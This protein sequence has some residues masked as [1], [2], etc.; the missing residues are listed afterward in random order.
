MLRKGAAQIP[1]CLG[2]RGRLVIQFMARAGKKL[3][4]DLLSDGTQRNPAVLKYKERCGR[5]QKETHLGREFV[6]RENHPLAN[7]V[8]NERNRSREE[9]GVTYKRA[10]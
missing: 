9:E 3:S 7:F 4:E 2:W 10:G 8:R 5:R 1:A 6:K